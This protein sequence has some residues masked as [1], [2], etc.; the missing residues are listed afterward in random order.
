MPHRDLG[1]ALGTADGEALR[2]DVAGTS[3]CFAM[4]VP[5]SRATS[6]FEEGQGHG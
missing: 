6:T 4:H 3:Q 1:A 2:E 5:T